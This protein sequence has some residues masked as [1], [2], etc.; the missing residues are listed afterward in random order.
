MCPLSLHL[1]PAGNTVSIRR[2]TGSDR[3]GVHSTAFGDEEAA[4]TVVVLP[5]RPS[6]MGVV[7]AMVA[8]AATW[9]PWWTHCLCTLWRE[10][11]GCVL[12][13]GLGGVERGVH[14]LLMLFLGLRECMY[15]RSC[16][17][18]VAST[19]SH[20]TAP[21]C[22]ACV[23]GCRRHEVCRLA[24]SY[25]SARTRSGAGSPRRSRHSTAGGA[26]TPHVPTAVTIAYK[27]L[28]ADVCERSG[29]LRVFA[30]SC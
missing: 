23:S 6:D 12:R 20:V 8:A 14:G 2:A 28:L 26:P 13:V 18:P 3:P 1:L 17:A 29:E 15:D 4:G 30:I 21:L 24:K 25:L 10:G 9:V 5:A 7:D 16:D 19:G 22:A 27:S 11:R